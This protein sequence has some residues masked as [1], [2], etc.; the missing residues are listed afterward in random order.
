MT[1]DKWSNFSSLLEMEASSLHFEVF[2]ITNQGHLN[3]A[4][5][6]I[7]DSIKASAISHIDNHLS[8][9]EQKREILPK[10]ISSLSNHIKSLNS[11]RNLLRPSKFPSNFDLLSSNYRS[12]NN[13][14]WIYYRTRIKYIL[15][16]FNLPNNFIGP[17]HISF[18]NISII[19][20]NIDELRKLLLAKYDSLYKSYDDERIKKFVQARCENFKDNQRLMLDSLLDCKKCSIVIDRLIIK[21]NN[22]SRLI[23]TPK[24]IKEKVN[25]HFQNCPSSVSGDKDIPP[26]W[27]SFY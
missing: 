13:N 22:T 2:P 25:E 3:F 9:T 4:W 21:D 26:E 11:L 20:S 6:R 14:N 19:R 5:D 8:S 24:E 23:T 18:S 10:S 7:R 15:Q 1:P 27:A 12:V 16:E 17:K